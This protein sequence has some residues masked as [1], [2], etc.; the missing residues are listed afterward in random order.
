MTSQIILLILMLIS[1][2]VNAYLH[3][4]P[5]KKHN[6]WSTFVAFVIWMTL[7]YTGGFF[8]KMLN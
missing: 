4:K 3:G 6:F 1:L 2:L 7:L 8:D 5:A